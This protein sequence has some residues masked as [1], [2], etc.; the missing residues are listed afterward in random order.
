MTGARPSGR[1]ERRLASRLRRGDPDA[2]AEIHR[3]FGGVVLGYLRNA[4]GDPAAAEDVHQEVFLEVWR[5]GP[6]YDPDRASL[7]TWVML[8]AR[9]RAIDHLRR[10]IPEPFDP[11]A[12]GAPEPEDLAASPDL[13]V[14]RWAMAVY[15]A[16]L[17]EEQAR[18]LRMRF[19][20]GLS[21]TEIAERTGIPLGTVK[22]YMVRGLRRLRELMEAEA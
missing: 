1:A 10:R 19:H 3:T 4:L 11:Q 7:G 21:Q 8:I 2:L 22:T 5:R 9:S 14:E 20:E 13:L 12:P 16:R 17:P 18:I 6:D 15:L